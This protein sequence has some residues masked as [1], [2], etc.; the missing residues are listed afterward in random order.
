MVPCNRNDFLAGRDP[1]AGLLVLVFLVFFAIAP[2]YHSQARAIVC[3][4]IVCLVATG[5]KCAPS[6]IRR[7]TSDS[8]RDDAFAH[9]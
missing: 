2:F 4:G 3:I 7:V 6:R 5:Q 9:T 1:A 8:V